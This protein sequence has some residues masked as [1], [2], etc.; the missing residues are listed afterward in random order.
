MNTDFEILQVTKSFIE[1]N[2]LGKKTHIDKGYLR[3]ALGEVL[4]WQQGRTNFTAKLMAL[5]A[6]ADNDN[7]KKIAKGF[8]EEVFAYFLWYH[9]EGLINNEKSEKYIENLREWLE[10]SMKDKE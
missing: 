5:I 7:K 2:L 1:V 9:K 6:K 8:A 10:D 3:W 4:G